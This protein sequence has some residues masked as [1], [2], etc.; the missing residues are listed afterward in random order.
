MLFQSLLESNDAKSSSSKSKMKLH[1]FAPLLRASWRLW[2]SWIRW[3]S[4]ASHEMTQGWPGKTKNKQTKTKNTHT[5]KSQR[6]TNKIWLSL[7]RWNGETI[8]ALSECVKT[9]ALRPSPQ[10][11][12]SAVYPDVMHSIEA[13]SH[14]LGKREMHIAMPEHCLAS[15]LSFSF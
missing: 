13:P 6:T 14:S 5:S 12:S 8:P 1:F 10:T 9:P 7:K 3:H 15:L 2:Q 4:Y 11:N